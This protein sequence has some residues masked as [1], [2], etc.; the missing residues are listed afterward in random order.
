MNYRQHGQPITSGMGVVVQMMVPADIAGV[1]F[2]A[3]PVTSD[4]SIM[5]INANYGLGE[6][7]C[8]LT[9]S[10]FVEVNY[11]LTFC[12]I[13]SAYHSVFTVLCWWRVKYQDSVL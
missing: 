9:S 6:V 7:S 8:F 11:P 5:L 3:D 1:L 12:I 4:C 10:L 13:V 2:T